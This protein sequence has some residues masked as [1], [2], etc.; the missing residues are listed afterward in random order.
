MRRKATTR[1]S[2]NHEEKSSPCAAGGGL[3][4]LLLLCQLLLLVVN[5][6]NRPLKIFLLFR[7]HSAGTQAAVS[8][9][10]TEGCT[11]ILLV[12]SSAFSLLVFGTPLS[13]ANKA[14]A[15]SRSLGLCCCSSSFR[16]LLAFTAGAGLAAGWVFLLPQRQEAPPSLIC[17]TARMWFQ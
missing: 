3:Q 12:S 1:R 10:R 8:F 4:G 15:G 7:R 17:L 14:A 11:C 2:K 6:G 13:R 9:R 16:L 5:D